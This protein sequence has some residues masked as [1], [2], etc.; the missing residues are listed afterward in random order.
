[1]LFVVV[2]FRGGGEGEQGSPCGD[3]EILLLVGTVILLLVG[4]VILLLVD[5]E[6]LL[7]GSDQTMKIITKRLIQI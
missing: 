6:I 5:T 1:M 7:G 2:Y 3:T 4:T